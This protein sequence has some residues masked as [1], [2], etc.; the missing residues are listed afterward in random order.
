[1]H[2]MSDDEVN[3]MIDEIN[4]QLDKEWQQEQMKGLGTRD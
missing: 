1:M 3:E 2:N 4:E